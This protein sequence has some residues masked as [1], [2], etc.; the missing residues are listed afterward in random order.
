M[1]PTLSVT[2]IRACLLALLVVL[3][4]VSLRARASDCTQ[5]VKLCYGWNAVWLQV[6]PQVDGKAKTADQV[7]QSAD[8]TIDSVASLIAPGGTAEFS[9]DQATLINQGGWDVW[10]LNPASGETDTILVQANHAYLVHVA[11]SGAGAI[12]GVA[13]QLAVSGQALFYPPAAALPQKPS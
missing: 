7:F 9:A 8:F 6:A 4:L 3:P 11:P 10:S 5:Q 12:G 13:G 1:N 2:S